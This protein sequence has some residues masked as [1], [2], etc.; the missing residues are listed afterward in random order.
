MYYLTYSGN[1]YE[2]HLYAVGY[3]TSA[4]PLGPYTKYQH[5]PILHQ[6]P[7]KGIY[8]P[9]HHSFFTAANGETVITFFPSSAFRCN[10]G[11]V[12]SRWRTDRAR[13]GFIPSCGG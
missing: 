1:G 2:S 5:N 6:A 3:A 4:S 10:D 8:G 7:E 12:L 9:G 13:R 11:D